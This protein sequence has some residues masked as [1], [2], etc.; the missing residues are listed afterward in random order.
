MWIEDKG[1]SEYLTRIG[2]SHNKEIASPNINS[3]ADEKPRDDR[4]SL[5]VWGVVMKLYFHFRMIIL[6]AI[7]IYDYNQEGRYKNQL[8]GY[9]TKRIYSPKKVAVELLLVVAL[10]VEM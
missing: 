5:K 6:A 3:T 2:Q 1:A 10:Y 8:L 9:C 7:W 4:D